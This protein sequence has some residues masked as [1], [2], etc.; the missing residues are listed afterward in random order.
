MNNKHVH[1]STLEDIL[2]S[3]NIRYT[4]E[5]EEINN[6]KKKIDVNPYRDII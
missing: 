3:S 4:Q 1:I 5:K 2:Y 6:N